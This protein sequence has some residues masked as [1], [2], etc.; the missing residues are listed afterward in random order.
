MSK[1]NGQPPDYAADD[2]EVVLTC[3]GIRNDFLEW[4]QRTAVKHELPVAVVAGIA[5]SFAVQ[6]R[7]VAEVQACRENAKLLKQLD[8]I[9]TKEKTT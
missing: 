6:A 9:T 4:L 7:A 8:E 5:Q 1:N 2:Q 3:E